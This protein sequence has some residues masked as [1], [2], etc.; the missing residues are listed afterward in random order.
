MRSSLVLSN[1]KIVK[2]LPRFHRQTMPDD[3][4]Q[5]I[6]YISAGKKPKVKEY[7]AS[8]ILRSS[9]K[10]VPVSL[11]LS[12]NFGGSWVLGFYDCETRTHAQI[13]MKYIDE[14]KEVSHRY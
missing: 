8:E 2:S 12:E 13:P 6:V 9:M 11:E 1:P 4:A 3:G 10:I 14:W 5:T 7:L